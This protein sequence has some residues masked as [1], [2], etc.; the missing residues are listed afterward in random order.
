MPVSGFSSRTYVAIPFDLTV[1]RSVQNNGT[2]RGGRMPSQV[3]AAPMT[4]PYVG[5]PQTLKGGYLVAFDPAT[6]TE[7]WRVD[8]GGGSGGGALVTASNLVFQTIGD[9][10]LRA[11]AADDGTLLWEVQTGRPGTGPPITF[12]LNGSQ[13]VSFLSGIGGASGLRPMVY[14]FVVDGKAA[15]PTTPSQ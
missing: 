4:P 13:H 9:G 12:Q 6:R 2:P 5:P 3:T 14:T 15:M 11:L 10:R 1:G 8:G 7:R